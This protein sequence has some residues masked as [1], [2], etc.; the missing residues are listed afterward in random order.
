[1]KVWT[2]FNYSERNGTPITHIIVHHTDGLM[3]GCAEWLCNPESKV[4]AHYLIE[5]DGNIHQ[6]V[7]DVKAAWHAGTKKWNRC[8]IGIELETAY[9]KPEFT[10]QQ[11]LSLRLIVWIIMNHYKIPVAN[12]LGHKEISP[13]RKTDPA[14]SMD[15]FRG[16]LETESIL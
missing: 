7:S 5:R 1:M 11:M 12:V 4:S 9:R 15:W 16:L 13:G 8:S 6:L 2:S 14:F 10:A 3:P